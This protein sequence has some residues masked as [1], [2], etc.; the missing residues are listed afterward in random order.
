MAPMSAPDP[1]NGGDEPYDRVI[2]ITGASSG[3]GAGLARQYSRESGVG[4][5]TLLA[6]ASRG[7]ARL[8]EV[9]RSCQSPVCDVDAVALDI[10]DRHAVASWLHLLRERAGRLDIVY[11]NAGVDGRELAAASEAGEPVFAEDVLQL[12][13]GVNVMGTI[14]T[15]GPALEIMSR[16]GSGQLGIVSSGTALLK[17]GNEL[18]GKSMPLA[19][20]YLASKEAQAALAKGLHFAYRELGVDVRA[21]YPGYVESD[22]TKRNKH[23]MHQLMSADEAAAEIARQMRGRPAAGGGVSL[24]GLPNRI[25]T[26]LLNC[27]CSVGGAACVDAFVPHKSLADEL[28]EGGGD[29]EEREWFPRPEPMQPPRVYD[30]EKGEVVED[31]T[32]SM[33]EKLS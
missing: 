22:I 28:R 14:N 2:A 19:V 29:A 27:C 5:R 4:R 1:A 10:S 33:Q 17:Y 7:R 16:Q 21:I 11:A 25:G 20:P 9:A 31:V 15:V 6:L 30:M 32:G 18:V 8:V 24:L 13:F 23:R 3:I 26:C 12:V